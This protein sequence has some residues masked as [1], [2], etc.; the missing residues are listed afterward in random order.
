MKKKTIILIL[1]LLFTISS[2]GQTSTNYEATS[3]AQ[4]KAT[5]EALAE[6]LLQAQQTIEGVA[7]ED[8]PKPTAIPTTIQP[9]TD[10]PYDILLSLPSAIEMEGML[11]LLFSL[12]YMVEIIPLSDLGQDSIPTDAVIITTIN[13]YTSLSS[14]Q[15]DNILEFV[16][17]GG[18]LIILQTPV[19]GNT[20]APLYVGTISSAE[21]GI[22]LGADYMGGIPQ[23]SDGYLPSVVL[24]DEIGLLDGVYVFGNGFHNSNTL[25]VSNEYKPLITLTGR[26]DQVVMAERNLG[27]GMILVMCFEPSYMINDWE[28]GLHDSLRFYHN[29]K[30]KV[31]DPIIF[32]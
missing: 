22:A 10:V 25:V 18:H 19:G 26:S 23:T 4:D 27:K 29:L 5:R 2:C 12:G 30:T 11:S 8:S 6:Q 14:I 13:G 16:N 7:Y 28:K 17:I 20:Y 31:L 32:E 21:L 24:D 15:R 9:R 1:F 3:V